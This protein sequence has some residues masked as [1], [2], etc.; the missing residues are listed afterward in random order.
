M[1]RFIKRV[2]I[3]TL[4]LYG[5]GALISSNPLKY[6][7]MNNQKCKVRPAMINFDSDE[8]FFYFY[9]V[10]VN[11]CSGS[12]NDINNPYPKLCVCD[13]VKK[14]NIEIFNLMSTTNETRYV[15]WDESCTYKCRLDASVC[16]S[17]QRWNNDKC[18]CECKEL[19]DKGKCDDGFIWNPI[20]CECECD[21]SC[22][23]G[24]FL[25]YVNC[26]FRKRLIDKLF[27]KCNEDID[28]NEMAYNASYGF[29]LN[30]KTCKSCML[31]VILLIIV[32]MIIVG[33][34][35][36]CFYFYRYVKANYVN[37]LFY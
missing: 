31:Y 4:T 2:F 27:E 16:S 32:C 29:V 10:P 12:C 6:V 1:F 22:D 5:R 24:E 13:V 7:L 23:V 28:G 30:K 19:R 26:N 37:V 18:R 15:S 35:R 9:N 20:M 14:T 25:D 36:A 17:R 33:I 3:A 34:C 8:P 11:K 21:K